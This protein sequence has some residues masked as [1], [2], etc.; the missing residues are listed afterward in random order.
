MV[1]H[2]RLLALGEE[3]QSNPVWVVIVALFSIFKYTDLSFYFEYTLT[4]LFWTMIWTITVITL[5]KEWNRVRKT[6]L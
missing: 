3:W 2:N 6:F 1:S 5:L 4:P